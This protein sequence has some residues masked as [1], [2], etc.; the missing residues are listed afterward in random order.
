L[1]QS[2]DRLESDLVPLTQEF[3]SLM[4]GVRRT[5]L[6]LLAQALQDKGAIQYTR[7]KIRIIDRAMLEALTCECYRAV[8]QEVL[9]DRIGVKLASSQPR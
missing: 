5:T 1:L 6:T 3:L 9:P 7:G 8:Q 2:S 4:L